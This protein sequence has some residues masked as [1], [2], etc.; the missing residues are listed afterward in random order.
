MS[1]SFIILFYYDNSMTGDAMSETVM[2]P[3]LD[4]LRF[5]VENLLIAYVTLLS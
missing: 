3:L 5:Q 2:I 1:Q 4:N